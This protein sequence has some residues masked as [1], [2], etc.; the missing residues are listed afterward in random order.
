M[1]FPDFAFLLLFR[2]GFEGLKIVCLSA[3]EHFP[4]SRDFVIF[5][6]SMSVYS[7]DHKSEARITSPKLQ[8]KSKVHLLKPS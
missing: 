4:Y 7:V 1:I 5:S 2:R 8:A 6:G 3:L